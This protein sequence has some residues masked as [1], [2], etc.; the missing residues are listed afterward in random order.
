MG[1]RNKTSNREKVNLQTNYKA[2]A[3]DQLSSKPSYGKGARV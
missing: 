1:T 3:P 2:T